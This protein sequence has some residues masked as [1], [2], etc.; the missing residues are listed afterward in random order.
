MKASELRIGNLVTLE[1]RPVKA[2]CISEYGEEAKILNKLQ[3]I[4]LTE[5]WLLKFGFYLYEEIN[6]DHFFGGRMLRAKGDHD[7]FVVVHG[8]EYHFIRDISSSAFDGS[9]EYRTTEIH[10][11]HQ[12]QNLYFALT[13]EE[14]KLYSLIN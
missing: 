5:E 1:G 7:E 4:P 10:Y 6:N 9:T 11:V 8:N 13:G 12:L 2:D 14:L 3:P